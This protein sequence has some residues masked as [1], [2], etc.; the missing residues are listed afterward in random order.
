MKN[1]LKIIFIL[2]ITI[3]SFYSLEKIY[4]F[5]DQNVISVKDYKA[6]GDG[7]TNDINAIKSAINAC[8][9]NTECTVF[10]PEGNYIIDNSITISKSN[11]RLLGENNSTISFKKDININNQI[12]II[13]V[14]TVNQDVNNIVIE[15][16]IINGNA[17]DSKYGKRSTDTLGR[18]ITVIR[19]GKYPGTK[20][21]YEM[22]NITIKDCTVKNTYTFGIAILGGEQLKKGYTK[23]EVNNLNNNTDD[24]FDLR[25]YYNYYNVN[26]VTIENCKI[27][28][29]RIGIR[30][31][32]VSNVLLENNEVIDS[33]LE[34]ITL[35][36]ESGIIK[37]NNVLSHSGGCG[38]I[39]LDKSENIKIINNNINDIESNAKDI[40]KTG[41]CQ[42]SSAGPSYNV[43][44]A[45]NNITGSS[46]GIWLK[47]HLKSANPHNKNDAGSRP[48]AGFIIK[49]NIINN[50]S[51][52]DI[53]ID[54]L[55]NSKVT[56]GEYVGK[57]Y[58]YN[59]YNNSIN[60]EL[61]SNNEVGTNKEIDNNIEIVKPSQIKIAKIN[62]LGNYISGSKLQIL[63][64]NG[65][66]YGTYTSKNSLIDIDLLLGNYTLK[67]LSSN[68]TVSF[69]VENDNYQ[70][71]YIYIIDKQNNSKNN[72]NDSKPINEN[73][74][75]EEKEKNNNDE[76]N[77]EINDNQIDD[78]TNNTKKNDNIE[79]KEKYNND[80]NNS[81]INDNQTDDNTKNN[82]YIFNE[83]NIIMLICILSCLLIII[84][85]TIYMIRKRE[86]RIK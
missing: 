9:E 54:E 49:D 11:I 79:E 55:L 70:K 23:E 39:C 80:E 48:G 44:I 68:K 42:N 10:F 14:K 18:G 72:D 4:A 40:D 45:N 6:K 47:N 63:D 56:N 15:N 82:K 27:S 77:S 59:N 58:L 61:Y 50:S 64:T 36:A 83:S 41:I 19:Q 71:K 75:I 74:N 73:N 78:N 33:R 43:F 51:I 24:D 20:N 60:L 26:N 85:I 62:E 35:Q 8:S 81:E 65:N 13:V 7:I 22:N 25:K 67:D 29:T 53:R 1:I 66:D 21:Y 2:I 46:R 86:P 31:N 38:N 37:D 28:K 69:S 34:N 16:L 57:S 30:L 5:D 84:L 17:T 52:T 32:R 3:I 76:D 12:G